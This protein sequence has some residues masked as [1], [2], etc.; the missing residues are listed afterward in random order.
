MSRMTSKG[1]VT[2]P[3]EVRDDLGIRPGDDVQ[4][5]RDHGIVRIRKGSVDFDAAYK[6]WAGY[7]GDLGGQT[8]DELIED[9]RGR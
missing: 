4:F 9:M 5:V 7:L 6:K 8:V 1:Q 3:K 2:I